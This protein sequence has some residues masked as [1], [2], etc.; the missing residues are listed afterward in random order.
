MDYLTLLTMDADFNHLEGVFLK[1]NKIDLE[2]YK[3]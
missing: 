3:K 2:K 1:L